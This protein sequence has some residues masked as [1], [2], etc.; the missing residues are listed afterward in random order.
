MLSLSHLKYFCDAA[1][2]GG[3]G[4][5]AERNRVS[6]SAVSQAVRGLESHFEVELL[7]HSR[8]RFELTSAGR[9]LLERSRVIFTSVESL[10][11][12]LK[13]TPGVYSGDVTFATQQ[14]IA[15]YLLPRFIV[16]MQKT[17]PD[18]QPKIKLA[19]TDVVK[20]WIETREVEF[21]LSVDNIAHDSFIAMPIYEGTFLYVKAKT[22]T[23]TKKA[24]ED[25]SFI[26]PGETTRE[27]ITFRR[28]FAEHFGRAPKIAMEIK[29]WGVVKRFAALGLGI[30]LI[31]DYLMRF[32][33]S[34]DLV[35]VG[36]DL[37]AIPYKINAFYC[38]KRK[39]LSRNSRA[40]LDALETYV[41][42]I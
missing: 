22:D 6:P 23:K 29:S 1:M 8:N 40:M 37:P 2:L 35:V 38:G 30:G 16:Q 32:D 5:A 3:I 11:E 42:S 33:P 25:H 14:S 31:P 36:N 17:H 41:K 9:E 19:P 20:K 12:Q 24:F 26:T 13:Q 15:H 34:P 21:G 18:L 10:E 27:S 28:D 7:R 4:Q 39:L